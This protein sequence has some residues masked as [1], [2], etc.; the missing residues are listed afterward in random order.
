M[1]SLLTY[2]GAVY[3]WHCDHIGHMNNM[4]YAGK[5]D[6]GSWNLLSQIGITPTYLRESGNGM[7][8]LEQ[9]TQF[10][11]E[12]MAGE[13]VE[14]R[15]EMIEV[16]EKIIR[17]THSMHNAETGVLAATCAIT[18]LHMN[19][20]IRKSRAFPEEIRRAAADIIPAHRA[21]A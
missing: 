2:R 17:F 11:A 14:V 20:L 12:V 16:R 6:E 3:P 10:K 9:H 13:V 19:K 4:W 18:G 5:F 8:A 7:V 21:A 15:S 1:Q